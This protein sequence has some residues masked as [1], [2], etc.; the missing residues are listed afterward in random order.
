MRIFVTG[1]TGLVGS[2]LVAALVAR[3]DV[4]VV[5][6]RD[7]NKAQQKLAPT[8]QILGG[9]PRRPGPWMESVSSCDGVIH[10]AGAGVF[11]ERWSPKFKRT[12]VE[13]RTLSTQNV[14]EALRRHPLREDGS[15]RVLVS[16]SAVGYYGPHG[17]EFLTEDYIATLDAKTEA[18]YR[19]HFA[20]RRS[21]QV[22]SS[23]HAQGVEMEL[24]AGRAEQ[25]G[26]GGVLTTKGPELAHEQETRQRPLAPFPPNAADFMIQLCRDWE[27]EAQKASTAGVRVAIIRVGIVLDKRGGALAQLLTPFR[28]GVG[29]PVGTGRQYMSWIHHE[30]LVRMY[31]WALDNPEVSGVL[32]GTAPNPVTNKAFGH[33]LGRALW[34]P[35]F[36]WTPAFVLFLLFGEAAA[37]VVN[38]QRVVPERVRQLGF[39]FRYPDID[40][41]LKEIL[42]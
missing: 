33:A 35:A 30:D 12:L 39:T 6:T 16:T 31:L 21:H 18:N 27:A 19:D 42:R 28:L 26:P 38:G 17:D 37:I 36:A 15:P 11:D 29:G 41:A 8:V 7:P 22:A 25:P 1:G 5:L 4:P 3:G 13:S 14:V 34:R 23:E 24:A 20:P 40:T 2:R 9:D 10:L 32:N